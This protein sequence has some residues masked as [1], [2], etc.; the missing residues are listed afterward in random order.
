VSAAISLVKPQSTELVAI[1]WGGLATGTVDAG[2]L[3]GVGALV[4]VV[5]LLGVG[6]Q[7]N[8]LAV[9]ARSVIPLA[10]Q[11]LLPGF[12]DIVSFDIADPA[13]YL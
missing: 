13:Y 9:A 5:V 10:K 6:L 3:A 8:K 12:L 7:L 2:A 11:S 1:T 4:T